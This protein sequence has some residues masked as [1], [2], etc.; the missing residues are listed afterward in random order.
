[1]QHSCLERFQG[2]TVNSDL[3]MRVSKVPLRYQTEEMSTACLLE[4]AGFPEKRDELLVDD[5]EQA[6]AVSPDLVSLWL[7]RGDDQRLVGGWGIQREGHS[8][9]IQRFDS[10]ESI[11]VRD[12]LRAC[13]EFIVRY[14]RF[15]GDVRA[16]TC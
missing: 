3:A 6:L 10:G 1:M 5:V 11:V 4:D 14:T 13:A 8:Y 15:I 16:R 9:R 7:D 2:V 12:R